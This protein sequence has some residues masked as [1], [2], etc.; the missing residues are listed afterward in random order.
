MFSIPVGHCSNVRH[1]VVWGSLALALLGWGA[2]FW[3]WAVHGDSAP[4]H[5]PFD[6][7]RTVAVVFS[8]TYTVAVVSPDKARIYA[9]GFR[10]GAAFA[11]G[12]HV[13]PEPTRLRSVR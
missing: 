13:A 2:T 1:T 5:T 12:H 3:I 11:E 10:D 4:A 7:A 9:I 8:I 6:I